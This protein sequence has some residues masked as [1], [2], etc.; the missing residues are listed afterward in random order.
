[1]AR[2]RV[3]A[4]VWL[5]AALLAASLLSKPMLVTFPFLLLLLDV[6]PLQRMNRGSVRRLLLEALRLAGRLVELG[7]GRDPN[8]LDLLAAA[9]AQVGRYADAVET[10][11]R[12]IR[13]AE[14]AGQT[15]L[16]R[17]IAGRLAFYRAR[18]PYRANGR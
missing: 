18:R 8:D 15:Q 16:A 13:L 2:A 17:V 9:Q 12:A 1:M 4:A 6:W 7:G 10:A 3:A 11:Q 5:A 14:A